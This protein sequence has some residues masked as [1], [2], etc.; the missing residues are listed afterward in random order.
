M[1]KDNPPGQHA[2]QTRQRPQLP[3]KED[4]VSMFSTSSGPVKDAKSAKAYL[5]SKA[6]FLQEEQ[7][8]LP[9]FSRILLTALLIKNIPP[10]AQTV[11]KAVAYAIED[12]ASDPFADSIVSKS[13]H[14][15]STSFSTSISPTTNLL[16][17]LAKDHADTLVAVKDIVQK[18]TDCLCKL[19]SLYDKARSADAATSPSTKPSW[20]QVAASPTSTP[21][22]FPTPSSINEMKTIQHIALATHRLLIVIDPSDP[23]FPNLGQTPDPAL[24]FREK[25]DSALTKY[26]PDTGNPPK[27]RA[28]TTLEGRGYLLE[29]ADPADITFISN[30]PDILSEITPS[31]HVK[32]PTFPIVL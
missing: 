14:A 7:L 1:S 27:I 22:N 28:C 3:S 32:K 17:A 18:S 4:L 25:L 11:I 8:N 31:A 6:W 16:S 12:A 20:A 29:A 30:H 26:P 24:C 23:L 10:E 21:P 2:T 13:T 9:K 19:E 5:A 15:L